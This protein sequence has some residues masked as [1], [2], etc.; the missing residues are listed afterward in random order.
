MRRAVE[1][2]NSQGRG[3]GALIAREYASAASAAAGRKAGR[4]TERKAGA[5]GRAEGRAKGRG[6]R[7]SGRQLASSAGKIGDVSAQ[8]GRCIGEDR[9]QSAQLALYRPAS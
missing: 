8:T 6:G 5:E 7:Q 9:L 3:I 4:K 1:G 2:S